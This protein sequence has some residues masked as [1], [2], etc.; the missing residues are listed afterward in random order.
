M[1]TLDETVTPIFATGTNDQDIDSLSTELL[2]P[3]LPEHDPKRD[4]PEY[5]PNGH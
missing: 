3:M 2:C 4:C 1:V 5:F